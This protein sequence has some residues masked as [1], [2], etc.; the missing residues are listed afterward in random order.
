MPRQQPGASRRYLNREPTIAEIER[1]V[2][3]MAYIV[4]TYGEQ[5]A[6]ILD[7]LVVALEEARRRGG[8]PTERARRILDEAE[9]DGRL[10]AAN[11]TRKR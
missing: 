8:S 6:P 2:L 5:Y 3:H 10:A 7:S 9:A 11:I 4:E 1:E